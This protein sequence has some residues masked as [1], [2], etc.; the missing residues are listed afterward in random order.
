MSM[1]DLV[2]DRSYVVKR[3]VLSERFAIAKR[4]RDDAKTFVAIKEQYEEK[5]GH[6]DLAAAYKLV[7]DR[8]SEIAEEIEKRECFDP[9]EEIKIRERD[10]INDIVRRHAEVAY[11]STDNY[12]RGW[13]ECGFSILKAIKNE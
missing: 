11:V 6:G 1:Q 5:A 13:V 12:A 9:T 4:L 3:A 10:R 2:I 7:S 8:L